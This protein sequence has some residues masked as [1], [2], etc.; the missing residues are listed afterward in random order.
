MLAQLKRTLWQGSQRID[1]CRHCGTTVKP[2]MNGC[3][4]CGSTEIAHYEF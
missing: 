4:A 1:E 3:P 2:S